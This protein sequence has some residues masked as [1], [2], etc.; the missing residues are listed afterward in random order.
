M[1]CALVITTSS[2][3]NLHWFIRVISVFE[4]SGKGK[5][6]GGTLAF[7]CGAIDGLLKN[8]RMALTV[9]IVTLLFGLRVFTS[10]TLVRLS[11]NLSTL[12]QYSS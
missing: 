11:S 8:V 12:P 3:G 7:R 10:G 9:L 6:V 1:K 4:A 2:A 5:E